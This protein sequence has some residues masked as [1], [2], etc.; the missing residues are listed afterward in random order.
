MN[1]LH[2]PPA[3]APNGAAVPSPHDLDS[4]LQQPY[5]TGDAAYAAALWRAT[6]QK[7][8]AGELPPARN[9]R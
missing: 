2:Q 6:I 1:T 8:S 3:H 4:L 7:L 9:T 5:R